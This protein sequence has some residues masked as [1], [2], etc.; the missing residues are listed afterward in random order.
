MAEDDSVL[1]QLTHPCT[2]PTH[3]DSGSSLGKRESILR[4]LLHVNAIQSDVINLIVEKAM[5]KCIGTCCDDDNKES[6]SLT[7][8]L[9]SQI[10]WLDY[11]VDP[12]K[13]TTFLLDTISSVPLVVKREIIGFLPEC[14]SDSG[15]SDV[16]EK[17]LENLDED[18]SLSVPILDAFTNL[19]LT[20]EAVS[21]I[22]IKVF[23]L[24]SSAATQDLPVVIKFLLSIAAQSL[25]PN[26]KDAMKERT[27]KIVHHIR[28]HLVRA[29]YMY[30]SRRYRVHLSFPLQSRSN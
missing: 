30:I 19:T 8:K 16:V 6:F 9:L 25:G 7:L 14:V 28:K 5:E 11:I 22:L 4:A 23:P 21:A 13:L 24:L 2:F 15:H 3:G 10:K 18:Q 12:E 26:N 29:M 20:D 1:L 27:V 17:L